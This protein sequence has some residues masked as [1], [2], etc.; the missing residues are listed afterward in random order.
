MRATSRDIR[1]GRDRSSWKIATT[2]HVKEGWPLHKGCLSHCKSTNATCASGSTTRVNLC[3]AVHADLDRTRQLVAFS[4]HTRRIRQGPCDKF[5]PKQ[6]E[7]DWIRFLARS[8]WLHNLQRTS[9]PRRSR[10]PRF[11]DGRQPDTRKT[12]GFGGW[13]QHIESRDVPLSIWLARDKSRMFTTIV[14]EGF[15]EVRELLIPR[16]SAYT[17]TNVTRNR[18][19]PAELKRSPSSEFIRGSSFSR[20]ALEFIER[21]RANVQ[22]RECSILPSIE[23]VW[24][25]CQPHRGTYRN[26]F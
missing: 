21:T 9:R 10:R 14:D 11:R 16:A 15:A 12:D 24:T 5:R 22:P 2:Q 7:S 20:S 3:G 17:A 1:R 19:P 23:M 8:S 6:C 25:T 13:Y 4:N 26:A 18:G